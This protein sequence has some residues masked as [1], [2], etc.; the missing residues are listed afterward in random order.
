MKAWFNRIAGVAAVTTALIALAG[1]GG[2]APTGMPLLAGGQS[3]MSADDML[4]AKAFQA[5]LAPNAARPTTWNNKIALY[6][7]RQALPMVLD[8]IDKAKRSVYFET[9]ELHDDQSAITI[10]DR[11][12]AKH[13]AG[14]EVRVI[15]D[16][17]GTKSAGSKTYQRLID[18]GVPTVVYGPF[19]YWR[20]GEKGLNI[21]HRK[22]YLVDGDRG[23]T[24]GMNL[25]DDYFVRDHDMLW[26]VEGEAAHILHQEFATD[27]RLGKGTA[28]INLPPAPTGSYGSEPIGIAV[29]SPREAGRE[30]EIHKVLLKAVDNAKTRIDIGYPFFWDD[31]LVDHL[32]KAEAR[33]VQVRV[34]LTK[35]SHSMTNKLDR[36]TAKNAIPKG[37]DF[38]WYSNATYAHIKYCVIDNSF[39]Q[40]GS[41]N[42]DGLTFFNNQELDLLLTNP[43]TVANFRSRISDPDWAG[44]VDLS[45]KDIDIPAS[46]KP[47]YSLLELIDKYM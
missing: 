3:A 6:P 39:L 24:G 34:I 32:A 43:Q 45:P 42:G 47:L 19:P 23:M 35:F 20:A 12:I 1:C 8:M 7:D 38:K 11:L 17:I 40:V 30:Q 18:H 36:W 2:R 46:Q 22:L 14:L 15:V 21:T 9:F 4:R 33:G 27:W 10:A 41:S 44:G 28:K 25:G 5:Q 29:T 37:I 16:R 13:K 26:M 31:A